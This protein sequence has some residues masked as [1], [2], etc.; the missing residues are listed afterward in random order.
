MV[1]KDRAELL[2]KTPE[3]REETFKYKI[4]RFK[5]LLWSDAS[6]QGEG[7]Y[8]IN[9]RD[10]H[11]EKRDGKGPKA[12]TNNPKPA[13][14]TDPKFWMGDVDQ[15]ID[16]A[17][18]CGHDGIAKSAM[19]PE[20]RKA[21]TSYIKQ[22]FRRYEVYKIIDCN[23][24]IL[25]PD[26]NCDKIVLQ[27]RSILEVLDM[28][29]QFIEVP[30]EDLDRASANTLFGQP[31]NGPKDKN[32]HYFKIYF[33]KERPSDA[34]VKIWQHDYWFYIDDKDIDSKIVFSSTA[35]ILSMAETG[36]AQGAPVLTLPVQEVTASRHLRV[37]FNRSYVIM[38]E[39]SSWLKM[40]QHLKLT[41]CE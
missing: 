9:C 21:V 2:D 3:P 32:K 26:P 41:N 13:D 10:C 15:K 19:K 1:D 31:L 30:T 14:F 40:E 36:P 16:K 27:T 38:K 6:P 37:G 23:Q 22:A 34:F 28:L 8:S 29:S 7:L 24:Y 5:E 33:S 18:T 35:G 12:H 17:I 20:E 39:E 4:K 11:G 25:Q